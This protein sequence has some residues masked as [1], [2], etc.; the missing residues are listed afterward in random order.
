[1]MVF[2]IVLFLQ[3]MADVKI[4]KMAKT[5]KLGDSVEVIKDYWN[6]TDTKK[7]I[8]K[9]GKLKEKHR[10]I[11]IVVI[12]EKKYMLHKNELKQVV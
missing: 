10:N 12:D 3:N 7:L 4:Y 9:K 1:M 5:I 8:G 2:V 11:W 6:D